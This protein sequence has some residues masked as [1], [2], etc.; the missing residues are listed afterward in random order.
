MVDHLSQ[1][2]STK[3]FPSKHYFLKKTF[4]YQIQTLYQ[5]QKKERTGQAC[6]K[7]NNIVANNLTFFV[8]TFLS[9]SLTA[10]LF[11]Y[12]DAYFD[13]PHGKDKDKDKDI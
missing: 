8:C 7:Q 4:S 1:N 5:I 13:H 2:P 10:I 12:A 3:E 11:I 9:S 6:L